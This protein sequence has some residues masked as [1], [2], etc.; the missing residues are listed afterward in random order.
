MNEL[1]E[2]AEWWIQ[3]WHA[4]SAPNKQ[5]KRAGPPAC[6]HGP[7]GRELARYLA[8]RRRAGELRGG[9]DPGEGMGR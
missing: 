5:A 3:T 4:I 1:L 8:L 9:A 6:G 7:Q 2:R